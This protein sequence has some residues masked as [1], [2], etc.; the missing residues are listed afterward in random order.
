VV[1]PYVFWIHE[2]VTVT[3]QPTEVA[4]AFWTDLQPLAQGHAN[5]TFELS[6]APETLRFPGY[7]IDGHVLWGMSYQMLQPLLA[8]L[9][10]FPEFIS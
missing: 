7:Q 4:Q 1:A 10:D 5:T 2:T 9:R 8:M 3:P 6:R